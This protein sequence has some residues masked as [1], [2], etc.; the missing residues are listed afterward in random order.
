MN[1]IDAAFVSEALE[2]I[3]AG[4]ATVNMRNGHS[5]FWG[6]DQV[7]LKLESTDHRVEWIFHN[8][9]HEI[10]EGADNINLIKNGGS[11]DDWDDGYFYSRLGNVNGL[12][13]K[14]SSGCHIR[15]GLTS[16]VEDTSLYENGYYIG[17]YPDKKVVRGCKAS[18]DKTCAK[19]DLNE[20]FLVRILR[21]SVTA[22]RNEEENPFDVIG[23]CAEE[24]TSMHAMVHI[25]ERDALGQLEGLF[26][27]CMV[28]SLDINGNYLT[29]AGVARLAPALEVPFSKV[30]NLDAGLNRI[31]D[32]GA[33]RIA[34]V[35]EKSSSRITT[36]D[37]SNNEIGDE[38]ASRLAEALGKEGCK[39]SKLWL[40]GNMIA[41]D[42]AMKLAETLEM[43]T[44]QLTLI[45]LAWNKIED[46]GAQNLIKA[47]SSPQCKVTEFTLDHNKYIDKKT[48]KMLTGLMSKCSRLVDLT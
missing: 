39:V 22:T 45:E 21:G 18:H 6:A 2:K 9:K 40:T 19:Y 46:E 25:K 15:F 24:G 11:Q 43:E 29:D 7:A 10:P 38:G 20:N 16:N 12:R 35:L 23:D 5:E 3:D 14:Q 27:I 36:L 47:I 42:G 33:I 17:I 32:K 13:V 28:T 26:V 30:V 8:T 34:E 44:C 41:D 4:E 1:P 37:L 31:R 48:K